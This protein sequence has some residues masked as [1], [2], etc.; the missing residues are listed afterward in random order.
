MRESKGLWLS[1]VVLVVLGCQTPDDG[2]GQVAGYTYFPLEAGRY[3]EY[4]VDE[5]R[6]TVTSST[7]KSIT[8]YLKEVCGHPYTGTT[9]IAQFPIERYKRGTPQASWVLDSVWTAYLLPD[10][11]VKVENNTA[12]VKLTFPLAEQ[13]TWNGN[14]LNSQ[15]TEEYEARFGV[16]FPTQNDYPGSVT[17]VQRRDSSLVSLYKRR[18]VYAPGIGLVFKEDI[19]WEYCQESECIGSGKIDTGTSRIMKIIGHGKE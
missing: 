3:T 12:F 11:A 14:L 2:V 16:P 10:R 15:S 6:Y 4:E 17:V 7:P 13:S 19:S 8:Y 1:L 5:V 18:E 9:G